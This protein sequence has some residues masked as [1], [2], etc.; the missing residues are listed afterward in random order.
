MSFTQRFSSGAEIKPANL[1]SLRDL[2]N[3]LPLHKQKRIIN[4]LAGP[5]TSAVRGRGIDFS[6]VREYQPGDDIRSMDWRVTARTGDP[7][8]KLFREERERPVLVVCDLR[9]SMHF[10]TRRALK[11]VLAADISALIAWAAM[12]NGDRIGGLIFNDQQEVDLRPKT[13][14]KQ[15][16]SLLHNMAE[17]EKSI[18]SDNHQR[19]Q[20]ICRHIRRI[21][22]PGSAIY[23]VS[24]WSGIDADCERQL[25]NVTRHCDLVA[26]QLYDPI[27]ADLPPPGLY[28]LTDRR[29]KLALDT[30]SQ[31]A[32][33]AH[34]QAFAHQQQQ[35]RQHM[36]RLK[37]PLIRIATNDDPLT[38][39]RSGL[40]L[41]QQASG[42]SL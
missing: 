32:R 24:D 37:V 10:G 20:Q 29:Q 41:T 11:S 6:E 3:Q 34:Q 28:N 7:H 2:A 27:E 39:L 21:A 5:H 9:A 23:F 40:G 4:D 1:V 42:R 36:L 31:T 30:H 18:A 26:V 22:R 35:I 12:T 13:G 17:I 38:S 25:F 8:I 14:R 33:E 15:V 16:L 19:M